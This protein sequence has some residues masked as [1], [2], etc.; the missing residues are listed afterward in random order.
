MA[1]IIVYS[2][3]RICDQTYYMRYVLSLQREKFL[4]YRKRASRGRQCE[5][6]DP[7]V[8][9]PSGSRGADSHHSPPSISVCSAACCLGSI[10]DLYSV[11]L[12]SGKGSP[13]ATW[14]SILPELPLRFGLP[15]EKP[16][17]QSPIPLCPF[18]YMYVIIFGMST[19]G[20]ID[21]AIGV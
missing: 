13:L 15:A 12:S 14:P 5:L 19:F 10:G 11:V 6:H 2:A 4:L 20:D 9:R 8:S 1:R 16:P 18:D 3:L 21:Q 17:H 7:F